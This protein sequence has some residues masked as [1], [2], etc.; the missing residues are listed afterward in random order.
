MA[1]SEDSNVETRV[2]SREHNSSPADSGK[3]DEQ[4]FRLL[5]V[6]N[7]LPITIKKRDV[8]SSSIGLSADTRQGE[9]EYKLSEG[10]LATALSG[11]KKKMKFIWIG[12]TGIPSCERAG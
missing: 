8:S 11:L 10:G 12:W 5:I 1:T 4:H 7:R 3:D 2:P 6:A 9:Y